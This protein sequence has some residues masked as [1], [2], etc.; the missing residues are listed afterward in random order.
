MEGKDLDAEEAPET[1]LKTIDQNELYNQIA[2]QTG[3]E[4]HSKYQIAEEE[5]A[6]K[7]WDAREA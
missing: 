5:A 6:Q 4:H 3:Y 7:Q 2:L 1:H